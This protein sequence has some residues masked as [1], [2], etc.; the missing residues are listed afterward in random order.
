MVK[1]TSQ[2]SKRS[3]TANE[4]AYIKQKVLEAIGESLGKPVT[5]H[6]VKGRYTYTVEVVNVT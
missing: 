5:D 2:Y 3:L 1:S 4:I 6:T